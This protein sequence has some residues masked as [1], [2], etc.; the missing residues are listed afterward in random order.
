MKQNWFYYMQITNTKNMIFFW[1]K[2]TLSALTIIHLPVI[3]F[4][5]EINEKEVVDFINKSN[6]YFKEK[7]IG[8]ILNLLADDFTYEVFISVG[9][10]TYDDKMNIDTYANNLRIFFNNNPIIQEYSDNIKELNITGDKVT[11]AFETTSNITVDKVTQMCSGSGTYELV[12]KDGRLLVQAMR[13]T[14]QCTMS[15][16]Q[17]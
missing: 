16:A 1:M 9:K 2:I 14:N 3:C 11:V 8:E 7:R 5:G 6:G 15:L 10:K 13:G 12:K 4:A 17:P